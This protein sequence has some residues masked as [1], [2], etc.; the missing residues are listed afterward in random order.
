MSGIKG[1][2]GRKITVDPPWGP[3]YTS[4]GGQEKLALKLGVSK[5]TVG[6]WCK[7]VHRVPALAKKELLRLCKHY[8][9][10]DGVEIFQ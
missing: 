6:K 2:S 3:L 9:I 8:E 10:S 1:K 4:V 7:G 5:G